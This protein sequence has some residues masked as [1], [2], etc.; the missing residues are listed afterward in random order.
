MTIYITL[1]SVGTI[2]V[3]L[4]KVENIYDLCKW[5][6][7]T[8]SVIVWNIETISANLLFVRDH[9]CNFLKHKDPFYK[10]KNNSAQGPS[11]QVSTHF[12]KSRELLCK[13]N[14]W[15][16]S[17]IVWNI[18]TIFANLLFGRDNFRN[19]LKHKDHF[20][21]NKSAQGPFL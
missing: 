14:T 20:Y 4:W 3:I 5:N 17:V 9:F 6:T 8:I 13:W 7:W 15:T 18:G 10:K 2:T 21:K 19:F 12:V 1:W 16:I 11:K